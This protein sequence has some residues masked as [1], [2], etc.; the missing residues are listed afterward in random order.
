LLL[1]RTENARDCAGVFRIKATAEEADYCAS[2]LYK[3]AS[4][5]M[6]FYRSTGI[7]K[8]EKAI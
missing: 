2:A 8:P 4:M 7:Q 5:V 3:Y 6:L 1:E